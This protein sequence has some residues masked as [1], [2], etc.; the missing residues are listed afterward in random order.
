MNST[1]SPIEAQRS[2]ATGGINLTGEIYSYQEAEKSPLSF[3]S[4]NLS[5]LSG[6]N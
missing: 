5:A 4:E 3:L 2:P 6:K 1:N